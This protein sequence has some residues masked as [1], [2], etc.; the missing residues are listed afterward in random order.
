MRKRR[1]ISRK[2]AGI[3]KRKGG[4]FKRSENKKRRK[5]RLDFRLKLDN[6][7]TNNGGY[8]QTENAR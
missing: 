5:N 8:G 6:R 7:L 4:G 1:D 3:R 2:I